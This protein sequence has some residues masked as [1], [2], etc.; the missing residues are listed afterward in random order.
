MVMPPKPKNA[1]VRFLNCGQV[2][3]TCGMTGSPGM[4]LIDEPPLPAAATAALLPANGALG[5]DC[6]VDPAAPT[7]WLGFMGMLPD[8]HTMRLRRLR[9]E[10]LQ[11]TATD[12]A[13]TCF[14]ARSQRQRSICNEATGASSRVR[15]GSL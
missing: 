4:V 12:A 10:S 7:L 1:I 5:M 3:S 14:S 9:A 8:E 15:G 2:L 11:N 6:A 13:C